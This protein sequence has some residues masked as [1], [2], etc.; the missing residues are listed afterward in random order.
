MKISYNWLKQYIN[1][2]QDPE[3]LSEI[4]TNCG[5]EVE[6]L[7]KIQSIKGGLKGVVIGEVIASNKH[8]NADRLTVNTVDVGQEF[9]LNIVCG[10]PNVKV[11]QKVPVATV[12]TVLYMGDQ[13]FEIKRTKIRGALSEGM[14]CAEDE[15]G[16]GTSHEGIV[17]LDTRSKVGTPASEYFKVSEDYVYEIGLTPNRTDAMSHIGVARDV[18][19][20]VNNIDAEKQPRMELQIPDVSSFTKDYDGRKIDVVVEDLQACPRYTGVTMTDVKIEESPEWLKNYLSALGVRPI[21]NIVDISNYVLFETGQPLHIFD[22]DHIKGDKV[23]VKKLNAGSKFT[24]LD[25]VE[26][27]LSENDLMICNIKEGMCIG[28]VFG[29]LKS[30][31]NEE[32][33]NIFIESANFD[34]KT[35]R[36]TSKYHGL[37]TDSSFR[38][39]RGVDP[40]NTVYALK[41]AALLIKDLAGGK[42]SSD[43]VDV[44]PEPLSKWTIKVSFRNVSRL[45]GKEIP[46]NMIRNILEDLGI[47]I[48]AEDEFGMMVSIPTFKLEVTREADIIEEILRIY[49]Y[50]NIEIPDEVRSSLSFSEKPDRGK[51]QNIISDYLS[52]NGYLEIMNNSLINSEY[53][54]QVKEHSDKEYVEIMNPVSQDLDMLRHNLLFGGLESIRYNINRKNNDLRLYEFGTTYLQNP[55][56]SVDSDILHRFIEEPHLAICITGKKDNE[57][58]YTSPNETDF[59]ELKGVVHNIFNRLGIDTDRTKTE[60][61]HSV[62]FESGLTYYLG[63]DLLVKFGKLNNE[64]LN[65]FDIKQEVF[66]A[67]FNWNVVIGQLKS[68]RVDYKDLTKYPEVRRD[69]ALLISKEIQFSEIVKIAF[70]TEKNILRRVSLFDV[71]EDEK[72]GSDKKSYAVSFILQDQKK[73]LTDKEIDKVMN[74]FIRAYQDQLKAMI[75]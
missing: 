74:K 60:N 45:I 47:E 72:I 4:L 11:G 22:A 50:N 61:L 68:S 38:F 21:N 43:I 2:N 8:P 49:G 36:K 70:Q 27:D 54:D 63:N 69:L 66:Y 10:A 42:V 7:E 26:R 18:M 41:R 13:E 15:L 31:V 40:N 55:D 51:V 23:I 5:L 14:I 75:R 20:V 62:V 32:T 59:Y 53:I 6:G 3:E 29:G 67:D 56:A 64:I 39:E 24:T 57:S 28:G 46:A 16:L 12:G 37:Q 65:K 33:K 30:G 1:L 73:T 35:I 17:E 25:E 71:F 34:A 58:W 19:A 9:L 52:A 48:V 44:Y